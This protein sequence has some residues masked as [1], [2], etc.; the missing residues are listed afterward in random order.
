MPKLITMAPHAHSSAVPPDGD[1]G[2]TSRS[3]AAGC[4]W[5]TAASV[6]VAS[7]SSISV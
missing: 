5:S 4:A 7:N 1:A 2:R 3:K 6:R